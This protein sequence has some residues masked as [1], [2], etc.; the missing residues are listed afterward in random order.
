[1]LS[2][3]PYLAKHATNM[4]HNHANAFALVYLW[5]HKVLHFECPKRVLVLWR[6]AECEQVRGL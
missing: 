6:Y 2:A 4:N 5:S 1:M 3:L